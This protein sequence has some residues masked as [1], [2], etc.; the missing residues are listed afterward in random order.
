M[1]SFQ[2]KITK[3]YKSNWYIKISIH[4]RW[5]LL[6]TMI[7]VGQ[8]IVFLIILNEKVGTFAAGYPNQYLENSKSQMGELY[9]QLLPSSLA[10]LTCH[11]LFYNI[12]V[13]I[14]H[15]FIHYFWRIYL[16]L[17]NY[18]HNVHLT[19]LSASNKMYKCFYNHGKHITCNVF[20]CFKITLE[21]KISQI[22]ELFN[23]KKFNVKKTP[24]NVNLCLT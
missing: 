20:Q 2:S 14:I 1:N 5:L 19:H 11:F 7:Y 4:V 9:K 18:V 13:N 21:N 8:K 24:L 16:Q 15:E 12:L 3:W 17:L 23:V 22:N 6:V 10:R